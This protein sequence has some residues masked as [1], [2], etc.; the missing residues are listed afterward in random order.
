M[1]DEELRLAIE[2][3][4][5]HTQKAPPG[6]ELEEAKRQLSM[7]RSAQIARA[8]DDGRLNYSG[9]TGPINPPRRK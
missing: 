9:D 3:A 8:S 6:P 7:L 2:Q 5:A 4:W 1:T